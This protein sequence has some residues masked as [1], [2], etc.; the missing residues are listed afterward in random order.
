MVVY[1]VQPTCSASFNWC[2]FAGKTSD[3]TCKL[4]HA[5]HMK[6]DIIH[7]HSILPQNTSPP[8]TLHTAGRLASE[9]N[10]IGPEILVEKSIW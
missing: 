4:S 9:T 8:I 3:H 10:Y 7:V 6:N 5:G 1:P 2:S